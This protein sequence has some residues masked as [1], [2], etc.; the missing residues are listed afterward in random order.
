MYKRNFMNEVNKQCVVFCVL[1]VKGGSSSSIT[2]LVTCV[3]VC[4][5]S[6]AG[7]KKCVCVCVCVCLYRATGQAADIIHLLV[8]KRRGCWVGSRQALALRMGSES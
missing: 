6:L 8:T 5:H 3:N 4:A 1:H 2:T 7:F